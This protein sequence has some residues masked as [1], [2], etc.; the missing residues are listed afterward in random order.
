MKVESLRDLYLEQLKDLYNAEHQL[1]KALPKMAK[2][3]S[4]EELRAAFT[5]HLGKT[6]EHAQPP[7]HSV[8]SITKSRDMVACARTRRH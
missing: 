3:A 1:T 2:A 4:S 5:D 7:L 8:W 6:R